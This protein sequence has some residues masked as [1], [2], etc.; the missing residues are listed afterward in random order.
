[1]LN[2]NGWSLPRPAA[3]NIVTC[4]KNCRKIDAIKEF[5]SATGASISEANSVISQFCNQTEE[6]II[7]KP[8]EFLEA[9]GY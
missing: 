6:G 7:I 3:E 5:R 4:I 9:F 1:M 8:R 2:R